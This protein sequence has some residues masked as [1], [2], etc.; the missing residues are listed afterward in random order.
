V[1]L[2]SF[3]ALWFMKRLFN[4]FRHGLFTFQL[5]FHKGLRY[6]VG[7][8]QATAL[9]SNAVLAPRSPVYAV[10]LA[11]QLAFYALALAG[12][13]L[14]GSSSIGM[15]RYPYYLCLLN[16]ASLMAL[17]KFLRGENIAVW[18]PRKG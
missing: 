7:V 8:L 13:L 16:G 9:V 5:F 18:K 12:F 10:L 1:I 11:A 4:P 17:W 14:R 3:H 6:L 15:V 2:R